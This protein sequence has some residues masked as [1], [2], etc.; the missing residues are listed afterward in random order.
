MFIRCYAF[1]FPIIGKCLKPRPK[2]PYIIT[3]GEEISI[4]FQNPFK[5]STTFLVNTEPAET[6][7][8]NSK[9]E[10]IKGRTT[11]DI[12]VKKKLRKSSGFLSDAIYPMAGKM[13]I[14]P[15]DPILSHIKWNYYLQD[16]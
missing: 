10:T 2:G 5:N 13:T 7:T 16:P 4:L 15:K 12:K 6:F 14:H 1:R 8:T 9:E 11:I 3:P